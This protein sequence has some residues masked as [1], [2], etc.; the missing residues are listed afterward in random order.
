MLQA[1]PRE[2]ALRK[3]SIE[4]WVPTSWNEIVGNYELKEL[5]QDMVWSIRVKGHCSG[6]NMLSHGTSRSGK[7][8]SLKCF[9][10]S[11]LCQE[12]DLK[13]LAPCQGSCS[14]CGQD[15]ARFG[16]RGIESY[17]EGM[18]FHYLPIDCASLTEPELREKL[19][20]LRDY[21]GVRIVYLD[22]VHRLARRNMDE[23]LLKQ[24][25]EKDF[26]WMA[27]AISTTGLEPAFLNRFYT[28]IKTELPTTAELASWLAQRCKDWAI[29]C[30]DRRLFVRIAERAN[31]VP[32]LALHVLARADKSRTRTLTLEMIERHRFTCED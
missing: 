26:I 12:L 24:M 13:T 20:E 18:A 9:A 17:I 25:D 6:H 14:A 27:S 5:L 11:V 10:R 23:Q 30:E 3:T 16:L 22:E 29:R 1:D 4:H 2:N 19:M 28:K 32:G 8:A 21:D 15:A 7:T 31:G